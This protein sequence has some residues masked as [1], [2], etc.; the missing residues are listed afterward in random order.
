[1]CELNDWTAILI[2]YRID[3]ELRLVIAVFTGEVRYP[4]LRAWHLELAE[5]PDYDP[6]FKG[7]GDMRR[8][9]MAVSREELEALDQLNAERRLVTGMWALLVDS[10]NETALAMV[11]ANVK[12]ERHPMHYFST[13]EA[14]SNYLGIDVSPFVD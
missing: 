6:T 4:E 9:S 2:D 12:K 7:I 5:R 13:V 10:P 11:Y 3:P 8:A 1:M 14:A